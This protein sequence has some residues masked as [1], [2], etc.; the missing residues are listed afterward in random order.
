ML[1]AAE[2]VEILKRTAKE[3]SDHTSKFLH[4]LHEK[5]PADSILQTMISA[6]PPS[7]SY[8][9]GCDYLPNQSAMCFR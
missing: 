4:K 9:D 6:S 1:L 2:L 3:I 5:K 7:L 8:E